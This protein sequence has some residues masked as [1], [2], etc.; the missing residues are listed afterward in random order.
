MHHVLG[1]CVSAQT[2]QVDARPELHARCH[3]LLNYRVAVQHH[4]KATWTAALIVTVT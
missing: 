1:T 2:I 4:A 3:Q